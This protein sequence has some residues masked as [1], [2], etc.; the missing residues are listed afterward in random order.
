MTDAWKKLTQH[1]IPRRLVCAVTLSVLLACRTEHPSSFAGTPVLRDDTL[2]HF[3]SGATAATYLRAEVEYIGLLTDTTGRAYVLASGVECSHC[4]ANLSVLLQAAGDVA[5]PPDTPVPGWY[6]YPGELREETGT[7]RF[8]SRL[9]WGRCVRGRGPGV[10]QFATEF[11][12]LGR[13]SRAVVRLTEIRDGRLV[14]DSLAYTPS[15]DTTVVARAD[16]T[17]CREIPPRVQW[18]L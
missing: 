6:P 13:Q 14:D 18:G 16:R 2:W 1:R 7:S 11:D 9:F 17:A 5:T 15:I 12:S 10:L 8:R 4:D 3:P